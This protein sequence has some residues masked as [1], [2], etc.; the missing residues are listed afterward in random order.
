MAFTATGSI[1]EAIFTVLP[2][3]GRADVRLGAIEWHMTRLA[4]AM[5][6]RRTSAIDAGRLAH[7]LAAG[8]DAIVHMDKAHIA[9]TALRLQA[10]TVPT[11]A[12]ADGI[13]TIMVVPVTLVAGMAA[14]LVW[15]HTIAV[16]RLVLADGHALAQRLVALVA[17]V[18]GTTL[19]RHAV[20]VGAIVD[21]AADRLAN[22]SAVVAHSI[23]L[24]ALAHIRRN[25][26][27]ILALLTALRLADAA[28]LLIIVALVTQ[29]NLRRE[30][31]AV[32]ATIMTLRQTL[33]AARQREREGRGRVSDSSGK[34]QVM[35]KALL[36]SPDCARSPHSRRA[37]PT[38]DSDWKIK[39]LI[40]LAE[41]VI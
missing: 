8:I 20:P 41:K 39:K 27:S 29:A 21:V 6:G 15:R 23:A 33:A 19:R 18:T 25:A 14:Q 9:G 22:T 13:A 4:S 35:G 3:A 1:A 30:A 38:Y 5:I 36:T 26:L 2:A 28:I 32:G 34:S 7:R 17:R 11:A 37:P 24:Q 12:A 31:F 10:E 16:L 40:R